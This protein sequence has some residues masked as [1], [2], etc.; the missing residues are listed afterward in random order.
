MKKA[1]D[2]AEGNANFINKMMG[3]QN[4]QALQREVQPH[5]GRNIDI[6]G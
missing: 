1:V 4:L 2:Q 5:L 6:K 3:E